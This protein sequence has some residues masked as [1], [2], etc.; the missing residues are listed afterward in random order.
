[1]DPFTLLA[2][3]VGTAISTALKPE[4]F[5]EIAIGGILGNRVDAG[6]VK[7]FNG[8]I[9]LVQG[10]SPNDQQELQRAIGRSMIAAQ[11]SIVKDC[12]GSARLSQVDRGW[13]Q[14]RR[15]EL[16]LD[17]KELVNLPGVSIASLAPKAIAAGV[18]LPEIN[19]ALKILERHDVAIYEQDKWRISIEL[20]RRWVAN[21]LYAQP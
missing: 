3:V 6:F 4:K 9:R 8:L 12:L 14:E 15:G 11:Q 7:G 1:L 13:L 10:G 20:F 19:A 2:A 5:A 21:K 18:T 17:L 16:D